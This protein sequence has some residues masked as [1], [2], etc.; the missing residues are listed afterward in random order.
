MQKGIIDYGER[1]VLLKI[2][3]FP[4]KKAV[5]QRNVNRISSIS[6]RVAEQTNSFFSFLLV[7]SSTFS[8][9]ILYVYYILDIDRLK[10]S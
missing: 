6:P 1:G 7:S 5:L 3:L 9:T 10:I 2:V 8:T 4:W